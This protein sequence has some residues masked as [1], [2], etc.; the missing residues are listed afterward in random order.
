MKR[1]ISGLPLF[2]TAATL[3]AQSASP[4]DASASPV[5]LSDKAAAGILAAGCGLMLIPI[6]ICGR[7]LALDSDLDH[8]GLSAPPVTE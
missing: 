3:L 8:E 4:G 5:E 1:L 2:F 6:L 7:H